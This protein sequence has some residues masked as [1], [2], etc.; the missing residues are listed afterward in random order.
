MIMDLYIVSGFGG[1]CDEEY[2]FDIVVVGRDNAESLYLSKLPPEEGYN[3]YEDLHSLN[4]FKG[5]VDNRGIVVPDIN[6]PIHTFT[7]RQQ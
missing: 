1:M 5:V 4:M 2:D 7:R 6:N 3:E